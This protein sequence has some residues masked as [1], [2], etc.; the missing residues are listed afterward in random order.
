VTVES[1]DGTE[2]ASIFVS[3]DRILIAASSEIRLGTLQ[4]VILELVGGVD[5][6]RSLFRPS[7]R[8]HSQHYEQDRPPYS[9][10]HGRSVS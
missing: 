2:F 3:L 1:T 7:W 6:W 10:L 4:K 9:P 5:T 8:Q